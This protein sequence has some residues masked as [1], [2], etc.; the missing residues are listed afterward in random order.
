MQY[1]KGFESVSVYTCAHCMYM[2]SE[3]ETESKL[4]TALFGSLC[5]LTY[6]T[7]K[8]LCLCRMMPQA[9]EYTCWPLFI[10]GY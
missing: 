7:D 5:S 3:M 4:R 8:G 9:C 1:L 6:M 2:W 10:W